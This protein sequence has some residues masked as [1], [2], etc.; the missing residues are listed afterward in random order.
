MPARWGINVVI[1]LLVI[2]TGLL[3]WRGMAPEPSGDGSPARL[4]PE[5]T[6]HAQVLT[7][8]ATDETGA[9]SYR[10]NAQSARYYQ[11]PDLWQLETPRWHLAQDEGTP[12]VGEANR[13]RVWDDA[14]R[15][16]LRGDV[17]LERKEDT[18]TTRLETTFMHLEIPERYAETDRAVSLV[19]PDF[20]VTS[21][22]ARAWLDE[23]RIE[24][25]NDA[26]GRHGA[27]DE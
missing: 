25:L 24:L 1:G 3:A 13:G 7:L 15:A 20:Q 11:Q 4:D 18:G 21:Q 23:E 22:G 9:L 10:V 2:L 17:V 8:T 19:G 14:T 5:I 6:A 16:D 27:S 26:R 12:W